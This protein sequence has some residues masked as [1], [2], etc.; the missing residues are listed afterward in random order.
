MAKECKREQ[1]LVVPMWGFND[2]IPNHPRRE[3]P[4]RNAKKIVLS[5]IN[6]FFCLELQTEKRSYSGYYFYPLKV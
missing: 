6:T 3:N 2:Q 4:K 1:V 5:E